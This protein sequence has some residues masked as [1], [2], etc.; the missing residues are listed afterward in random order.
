LTECNAIGSRIRL[1]A[2]IG[3]TFTD[4]A[5]FDPSDGRLVF[6]KT[7]STPDSLIDGIAQGVDKTGIAFPQASLFLHGSTV[8]INTMLERTGARTALLITEGF[9]DIYEIG[10]VNRPD[11]YNLFFQ[12]HEP[13][14]ERALRFEVEE[15]LYAEGE[16]Y[17]PL[18]EN[19]VR[20]TCARLRLERVEAVAILLLHCY[21]NPAHELRVR[22]IVEE[23]LPDVF[24]S[25]SHELSQEYREFERCSTVVANAYIGPKVKSYIAG[26]DDRIRKDG[27]DGS[28]LVV[29]STGG[30]YDGDQAQRQCVRMLESGPAAGVIGTQA[31]CDA[32]GLENAIAFDMGGT[33]A[34]AGVI[35]EG[36]ALTTGSA[37]IGGYERALPVQIAMMDIFEVGT[38]GGSIAR[39]ADEGGLRVGPQSAGAQPGP[40]CYGQGGRIPTVTDANVY[41]GRLSPDRFLGGEMTLDLALASEAINEKVA[42]PL[43]LETADAAQGILRIA[44]TSMSHAVKAV[45][46]ERGLNAGDFA[47]VAYGGAGPLHACNIAREMGIQ[48]VIIPYSPGHFSAF[49]MLFSDLRYDYVRS[50]FSRLSDA[51]FEELETVFNEL[52]AEGISEIKRVSTTPERIVV[53]RAADMR[54]VGQEHSVTVD[55]SADLFTNE[56]RAGIKER[57][58]AV[59]DLRYGTCAPQE[60]SEIVSLRVTVTGMLEKPELTRIDRGGETPSDGSHTGMRQVRFG[61]EKVDTDTW[62]RT[63]LLAGNTI[64]GPALIEEHASTTVLHPGDTLVV[65]SYGNLNI[66]IGS[67]AL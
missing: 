4:V 1:A 7:L 47:M 16:I 30:L 23:E 57:F 3:G 27:F 52:E 64:N 40:A 67:D 22:Q 12:K 10:R 19:R 60:R 44:V 8:A 38:G 51:N 5:A 58:D 25:T 49:G 55:L 37:L 61:H 13:L 63:C 33:T 48:K 43:N 26:I 39:V 34:K 66:T 2:D 17:K 62:D 18:D 29:Q 56:D 45:T 53:S 54:Y 14:V 11:A 35:H 31:L 6:G 32:I 9:R 42:I 28:F 21:A 15:R 46:T 41:L 65:D 36:Q 20:E 59:H 50:R 24:V